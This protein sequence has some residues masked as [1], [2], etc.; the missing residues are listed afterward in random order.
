VEVERENDDDEADDQADGGHGQAL[1]SWEDHLPL[2]SREIRRKVVMRDA[3]RGCALANFTG[4][5]R[6]AGWPG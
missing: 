6:L 4:C 1:G 5:C 3:R 2:T